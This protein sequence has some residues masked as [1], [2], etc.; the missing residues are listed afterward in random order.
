MPF[1]VKISQFTPVQNLEPEDSLTIIRV[2]G[3]YGNTNKNVT[4]PNLE[5]YIL[6]R[7]DGSGI[8]VSGSSAITG[9]LTLTGDLTVAGAVLTRLSISASQVD[10]GDNRILLNAFNSEFSSASRYTGIDVQDSG[11]GGITSSFLWDSLLDKWQLSSLSASGYVSASTINAGTSVTSPIAIFTNTTSSNITASGYVSASTINAVTSATSPIGIFTNITASNISAS[12]YVSASTINA[13]TS[14]TSPIGFFT[15]ITASNIS[16]SGFVSASSVIVS[17]DLIITGS[18]KFSAGSNTIATTSSKYIIVSEPTSSYKSAFYNYFVSSGS[19]LRA[20]SI[21]SI[22]AGSN[23][24]YAE[25]S[26]TDIGNTNEVTMSVGLS[27]TAV[28]LSSSV[29]TTTG[30]IVKASATYI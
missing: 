20:G 12:G 24:T 21:F 23:I 28:Q 9:N 5:E 3:Q 27:G 14:V 4:V 11:S 22:F 29:S 17:G 10:L 8:Q 16:A 2:D 18:V 1:K 30:W 7:Q 6:G 25:L 26:T 15:N 13:V 19:N